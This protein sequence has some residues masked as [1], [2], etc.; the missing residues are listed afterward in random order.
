MPPFVRIAQRHRW[1]VLLKY[2]ATEK[3]ILAVE[4][5]REVCPSSVYLG[6]DVDPLSID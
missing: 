4:K 5:L 1:H 2:P 6:I 3:V